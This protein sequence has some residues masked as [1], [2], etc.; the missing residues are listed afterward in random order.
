MTVDFVQ[1]SLTLLVLLLFFLR[2]LYRV[3]A[4]KQSLS[5]TGQ[6]VSSVSKIVVHPDYTRY[7]P[8]NDVAQGNDPNVPSNGE[9]RRKV[10]NILIA[11]NY[12]K[13]IALILMFFL[14]ANSET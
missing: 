4:G 1:I 12:S 11:P 7:V 13:T 3:R 6:Q 2:R 14:K 9:T 5:E 10:T 8:I